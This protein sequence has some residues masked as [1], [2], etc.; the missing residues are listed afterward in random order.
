MLW[1][2]GESDTNPGL[3]ESYETRFAAFL[4]RFRS[5]L[6]AP[7]LPVILAQLNR[8]TGHQS[9]YEHRGWS[10]VREAQRNARRLGN[11]A[12]V[13]TLDLPICDDCHTSPQGNL[14]MGLRKAQAAL[15]LVYRKAPRLSFPDIVEA[16]R[17]L[18][19]RT[20]ELTFAGVTSRLIWIAPD[21]R[22]FVVE[23]G[24]AQIAIR[25]AEC[26]ARDRVR[27]TLERPVSGAARVHGAFGATR[28]PT[29]ATPS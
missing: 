28:R 16:V 6:S 24:H 9:Q 18:D 2:Q 26:F 25:K 23:E 15:E 4:A 3:A 8:Y 13:P 5:D 12:V 17:G 14:L 21:E 22:D 7:D 27:L 10:I 11:V 20:I 29:C 19:G 1:Y